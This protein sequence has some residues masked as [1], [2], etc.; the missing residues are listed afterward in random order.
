MTNLILDRLK[1]LGKINLQGNTLEGINVSKSI[2]MIEPYEQQIERSQ[3]M[4]V[5]TGEID[6]ILT[7]HITQY[8]QVIDCTKILTNDPTVKEYLEEINITS[9][10]AGQYSYVKEKRANLYS[11]AVQVLKRIDIQS[12][13][14]ELNIGYIYANLIINF[15]D[16]LN[17]NSIDQDEIFKI[18]LI[19]G[20][21]ANLERL[22]ERLA[23]TILS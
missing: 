3:I 2:E 4:G 22:C 16:S 9:I 18:N 14:K 13:R 10:N 1:A 23:I 17:E 12:K 15:I 7:L 21:L 19:L 8:T 20:D 5:I 11:I 6:K